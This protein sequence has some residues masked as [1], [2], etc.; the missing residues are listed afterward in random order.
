MIFLYF[1]KPEF[2]LFGLDTNRLVFLLGSEFFF[3]T[4][5]VNWI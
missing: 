2:F 1:E 3:C 5:F 4:I